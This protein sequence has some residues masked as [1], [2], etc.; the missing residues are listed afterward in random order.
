MTT[1]HAGPSEVGTHTRHH[2]A[3]RESKLR[4]SYTDP[5]GY[6][7]AGEEAGAASQKCA[8]RRYRTGVVG[9]YREQRGRQ[10]ICAVE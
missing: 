2:P 7:C 4:K 3:K 1:L 8:Y 10:S 5:D 6:L 9:Y